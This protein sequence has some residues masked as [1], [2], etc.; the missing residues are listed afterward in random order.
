[1]LVKLYL[2]KMSACF[3]FIFSHSDLFLVQFSIGGVAILFENW[4]IQ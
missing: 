1:M 2:A 4:K 3:Y